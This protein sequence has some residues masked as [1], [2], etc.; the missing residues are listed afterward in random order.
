LTVIARTARDRIGGSGGLV[1]VG[2]DGE[3]TPTFNCSGM[4]RGYVKS[5]GIVY[6]A[7]YKEAYRSA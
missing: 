5:D 6:T 1:A 3:P 4:Y 7:V 2:R